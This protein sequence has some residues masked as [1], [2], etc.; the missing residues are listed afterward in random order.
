V[1]VNGAGP[2]RVMHEGPSRFVFQ[3]GSGNAHRGEGVLQVARKAGLTRLYIVARQDFASQEIAEATRIAAVAQGFTVP[4]V[5]SYSAYTLDFIPYVD[6]ALRL[7]AQAWIAIAEA[8]DAADMVKT[9]RK[10]GFTP[11]LFYARR[12]AEPAFIAAVGQ[13]AEFTL[14]EIDY[15]PGSKRPAN[16][17]FVKAYTARWSAAPGL[18]AAEGYGA[19]SVLGEAVRRA[20][21]LES[22]KLRATLSKLQTE[23]PLGAYRVGPNG[24]Q[25]GMVPAVAQIQRGKPQIVW[26]AELQSAAPLQ[27]YLPWKERQLIQ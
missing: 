13:D 6:R 20:G 9:F 15:D 5:E 17:E 11:Q 10:T 16:A 27:P 21:S 12:A 4:E 14:A 2:A 22:E 19:A 24:E 25:L 26:P 3:T 8:R 1:M 18:A 23:T 7:K